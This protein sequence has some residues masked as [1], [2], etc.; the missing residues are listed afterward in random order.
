MRAVHRMIGAVAAL[1]LAGAVPAIGYAAEEGFLPLGFGDGSIEAVEEASSEAQEPQPIPGRAL[2]LYRVDEEASSG[3]RFRSAP[4]E[5]APLSD[6]GFTVAETWDFSVVDEQVDARPLSRSL[7]VDSSDA[8]GSAVPTGE[9]VRIALVERAGAD[10]WDLVAELEQVD[11]VIAAQPS[12]AMGVASTGSTA[13]TLTGWQYSLYDD[14]AGIDFDAVLKQQVDGDPDEQIVAVVDTGVDA[15]NPDLA[16]QM[17]HKPAGLDALPGETGAIGYDFGEMDDDPAPGPSM[18][19]SHGTHCAGIISATANNGQG[20]AGAADTKIMAL[21]ICPDGTNGGFSD[22]GVINAFQ[23]LVAAR[24]AGLNVVAAN[25]SWHT[26]AYNPV[27]DYLINQAGRLGVVSLI[28]AGNSALDTAGDASVGTTVGIES[29]YAVVIAASNDRN[30]LA[31]Y[32]NWNETQVDIAFPGSNIISTVST[33]AARSFFSPR[34]AHDHGEDLLYYHNFSDFETAPRNYRVR[35]LDLVNKEEISPEGIVTLEPSEVHGEPA[36]QVTVNPSR[37]PEGTVLSQYQVIV[38]WQ[39]ENPLKGSDLAAEDLGLS[40]TPYV[41]SSTVPRDFE[42][43]VYPSANSSELGYL[44]DTRANL[45][46]AKYDNYQIFDTAMSAVDAES[47]TLTGTVALQMGAG[48]FQEPVVMRISGYGIGRIAGEDSDYTPYA[49][50]SGTSMATP[51]ATGSFA[52][53]A[54]LYPDESPLE[55]RGRLVGAAE[56]IEPTYDAQGGERLTATDGRFSFETALDDGGLSAN[57]WSIEVDPA[58]GAAELHGRAL[59]DATLT[60]DGDEVTAE[61][62]EDGSALSFTLPADALDGSSH[63]FDVRDA[64]TGRTHRASYTV[65]AAEDDPAATALV[66]ELDLPAGFSGAPLIAAGPDRLFL[67]DQAGTCLYAHPWPASEGD[68]WTELPAPPTFTGRGEAGGWDTLDTYAYFDGALYAVRTLALEADPASGAGTV[69]V[70]AA[71]YDI[72]AGAW[73]PVERAGTLTS[74]VD[75]STVGIRAV[76]HDGALYVLASAPISAEGAGQGAVSGQTVVRIDASGAMTELPCTADAAGVLSWLSLSE[77]DG[78]LTALVCERTG[79]TFRVLTWDEGSSSWRD[80]GAVAG[81]PDLTDVEVDNLL[82]CVRT[83]TEDGW[84]LTGRAFGASGDTA[85][86]APDEDGTWTWTGLGT[87]GTSASEGIAV[88]SSAMAGGDVLFAGV[89]G[90]SDGASGIWS[91]PDDLAARAGTLARTARATAASGGTASVADWRGEA[92]G[93]LAMRRGDTAVWTA[94]AD[95][96]FTFAGWY[97]AAGALVSTDAVH[98]A[99]LADDTVL[100]AR[101]TAAGA[102]GG[103]AGGSADAGGGSGSR[104]DLPATGDPAAAVGALL[105]LGAAGVAAGTRIRRRAD[106]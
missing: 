47:D 60:V 34:I 94:E 38:G 45:I 68:A 11:G 85:L 22:V 19:D 71:R 80:A 75:E 86:I 89:D 62:S 87:L 33:S 8:D 100:E 43:V 53:L 65:P 82:R 37:L 51:L 42:A 104:G 31:T 40:V 70:F 84:V 17:W 12:Y 101:F 103:D 67:S 91:L 52:R 29:P 90:A 25:C 78:Q 95:D 48:A 69:G 81:A 9:D 32:S 63:R 18:A 93:E 57:T 13:D 76:A 4:D 27:F 44:T 3:A 5:A 79:E 10:P 96:G 55:L 98:R 15:A 20:I 49:L 105:A 46:L 92:A 2:V 7:G 56:D 28:A 23:Y 35:L 30:E 24:L 21:K 54:D 16:D 83:A 88:A 14:D 99:A 41:V 102:D 97:D 1:A 50:M 77:S 73:G 61:A 26:G 106:R 58:T 59:D 74:A 6:A 66:R 36:L 39:M 72:A 64:S